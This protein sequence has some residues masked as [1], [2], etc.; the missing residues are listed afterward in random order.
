MYEDA[1]IYRELAPLLRVRPELQQL[2]EF[3]GQ[4]ESLH[5][6]ER[7]SWAPFHIVTHGECLIDVGA[8]IGIH[9]KTGDIAVLPHG[10]QH[11]VRALP[12]ADQPIAPVRTQRRL[13]DELV[14]KSDTKLICGRCCFEQAHD[15]LVLAALPAIVVLSPDTARD[16]ARL[17]GITIAMCNELEDDRLGSAIVAAS[18]AS[19]LMLLVLRAH[20]EAAP[21]RGGIFALLA[22]PQTARALSAMLANPAQGFTLDELADIAATSRATL[23]RLFQ[24]A[25]D[26][27]PLAYLAELRLGLARHRIMA[28]NVALVVIAEDVGYQSESSFSR[29]YHRRFG[30]APGADRRV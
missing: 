16:G 22:K 6:P 2:C 1:D 25:V 26:I 28:S 21:T 5:E 8:D 14:I 4:W 20:F 3:G 24:K 7:E 9:L 13:H 23:V 12:T 17:S 30:V 11:I 10:G 19:S 29:A 18:L 15:N 27:A